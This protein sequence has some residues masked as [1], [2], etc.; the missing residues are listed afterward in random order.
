MSGCTCNI[1]LNTPCKECTTFNEDEIGAFI[2]DEE[3]E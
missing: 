1:L 3:D 2:E